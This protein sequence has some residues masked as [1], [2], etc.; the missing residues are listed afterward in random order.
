MAEG[1][2][3]QAT[4]KLEYRDPYRLPVGFS[5]GYLGFG[6]SLGSI[7][8]HLEAVHPKILHFC[9]VINKKEIYYFWN[10]HTTVA[11]DKSQMTESSFNLR[12]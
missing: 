6:F 5:Y 4:A 1:G 3:T 12:L 11:R 2:T 8:A 7:F 9:R 10:C